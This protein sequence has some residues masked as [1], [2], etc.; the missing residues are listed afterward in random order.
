MASKLISRHM[1]KLRNVYYVFVLISS[2]FYFFSSLRRGDQSTVFCIVSVHYPGNYN[3][4]KSRLPKQWPSCKHSNGIRLRES[5][6]VQGKRP[7]QIVMDLLVT[8]YRKGCI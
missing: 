4:E 1:A 3:W 5:P 6:F 7:F 2:L 8:V